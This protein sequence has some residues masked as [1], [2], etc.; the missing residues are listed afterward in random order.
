[1]RIIGFNFT[2]VLAEKALG[3]SAGSEI[4]TNI[5]FKNIEKE[6]SD[7]TK[8]SSE[9]IKLS[10]EFKVEYNKKET[11]EN[12]EKNAKNGEIILDGIII[13]LA[14][15]DEAK[16]IFKD[17]E[18]KELQPSF[19]IP[20]FNFILNKCSIRALQLEEELGLPMHIPMP[21]LKTAAQEKDQD[22]DKK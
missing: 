10:F 20:I 22:K 11:K 7:L 21:K 6:E 9:V 14:S 2:K 15:K 13:L 19:K 18:K 8:E 5:E 1:M 17:W 4:S 3:F 16:T 12:K